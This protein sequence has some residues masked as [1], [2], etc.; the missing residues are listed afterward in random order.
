MRSGY[1]QS[2]QKE[3]YIFS[4]D[5]ALNLVRLS[6]SNCGSRIGPEGRGGGQV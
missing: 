3:R 4:E 5:P 1:Q 2:H 6:G